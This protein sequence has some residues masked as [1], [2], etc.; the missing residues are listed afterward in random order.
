MVEGKAKVVRDN[1]TK[2]NTCYGPW[3]QRHWRKQQRSV[4][5][6]VPSTW[7]QPQQPAS[8]GT[9]KEV[10][11]LGDSAPAVP[12]RFPPFQSSLLSL[13]VPSQVY[14]V[15]YH[16]G[17]TKNP[18]TPIIPICF[19]N[20]SPTTACDSELDPSHPRLGTRLEFALPTCLDNSTIIH[21]VAYPC[22]PTN[23]LFCADHPL[24]LFPSPHPNHPLLLRDDLSRPLTILPPPPP[25]R[26][27]QPRLV[28]QLP[29][30]PT[31]RNFLSL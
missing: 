2:V 13:C 29:T 23:G 1:R 9:W 22:D 26:L 25:A 10:G 20:T 6:R 30:R 14:S 19:A 16:T 8:D 3:C 5:A 15:P 18:S 12:S 28:S 27:K 24:P 4:T 17:S 7:T 11:P 21:S 31:H